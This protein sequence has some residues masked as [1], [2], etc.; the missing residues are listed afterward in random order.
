MIGKCS[1]ISKVKG[2]NFAAY[3]GGAVRVSDRVPSSVDEV[4]VGIKGNE[5]TYKKIT[6]FKD[7]YGKVME[8]VFDYPRNFVKNKVY[9]REINVLGNEEGI[10]STTIKDYIIPRKVLK[11]LGK[12]NNYFSEFERMSLKNSKT[13]T[14]HV[15]IDIENDMFTLSQ[16]KIENKPGTQKQQHSFIEFPRIKNGKVVNAKPRSLIFDVKSKDNSVVEGTVKASKYVEAPKND[17]F[18]GFRA[19]SIEDSKIPFIFKFL[20]E[21]NMFNKGIIIRPNFVSTGGND[22]F[23]AFFTPNDGSI[24]INK[25]ANFPSKSRLINTI[26]HEVEHSWQFFL[27]GLLNGGGKNWQNRMARKFG[28]IT[29]E[30]LLKEAKT[31]DEPIKNYVPFYVDREQYYNNYIEVKARERGRKVQDAYDFDGIDLR[32]NFKHIP[33]YLL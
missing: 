20:K 11:K 27:Q 33:P 8:R 17:K 16:V 6:T 28:K 12:Y 18:L 5:K 1:L 25:R 26:S 10:E 4:V 19:L 31:Y 2:M 15:S 3:K 14:N 32:K 24:N 23:N 9:S 30:N 13:L 7:A 22:N 21:R 29:D